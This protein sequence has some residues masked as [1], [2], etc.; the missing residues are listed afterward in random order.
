MVHGKPRAYGYGR[1]STTTHGSRNLTAGVSRKRRAPTTRPS[2]SLGQAGTHSQVR[3]SG[4]FASVSIRCVGAC[5]ARPHCR[6]LQWTTHDDQIVCRRQGCLEPVRSKP[7]GVVITGHR[8]FDCR[9][10]SIGSEPRGKPALHPSHHEL[11]RLPHWVGTRTIPAGMSMSRAN[12]NLMSANCF[13]QAEAARSRRTCP[14]RLSHSYR[15]A[16]R[17]GT[18]F[19]WWNRTLS[20]AT[21]VTSSA[22]RSTL[23]R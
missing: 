1:S 15:P 6:S 21:V 16:N 20:R 3:Q 9:R 18:Y 23:S 11:D 17:G 14:R 13:Q 7:G 5:G 10:A 2:S 12:G 4:G 8:Y 19:P 22:N